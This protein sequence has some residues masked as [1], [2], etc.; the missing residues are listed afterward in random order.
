MLQSVACAVHFFAPCFELSV[1]MGSLLTGI[2]YLLQIVN[3]L[4]ARW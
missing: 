2:R 3:V 4:A 1:K